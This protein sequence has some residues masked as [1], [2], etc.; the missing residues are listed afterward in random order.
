VNRVL[1]LARKETLEILRDFRTLF[2][3]LFLPIFLYPVLVIGVTFYAAR[4]QTEQARI[5]VVVGVHRCPPELLRSPHFRQG[6]RLVHIPDRASPDNFRVPLER[7]LY[8]AM[9]DC[10]GIHS[11][12][13]RPIRIFYLS[14][15]TD[16]ALA[17]QRVSLAF[18][19]FRESWLLRSLQDLGFSSD[20][21]RAFNP[22]SQD[23]SPPAR[24]SGFILAQILPL[25]LVLVIL[26]GAYHPSMD[27]VVGERERKTVEALLSSPVTAWDILVAKT[28]VISGVAWLAGVLNLVSLTLNLNF[29][30]RLS[31]ELS[32]SLFPGYAP[33]VLVL[34]EMIPLALLF[35]SLFVS[36]SAYS[37]TFRESQSHLVPIIFLVIAP[38][39]VMFLAIPAPSPA[40]HSIPVFSS[41]YLMKATLLGT[42]DPVM[43]VFSSALAVAA[44]ALLLRWGAFLWTSER[45]LYGAGESGLIR[46][47]IPGVVTAT[48]ALAVF[49]VVSFGT[50]VVQALLVPFSVPLAMLASHIAVMGGGV[51]LIILSKRAPLVRTLR[52]FPLG[53]RAIT[54]SVLFGVAAI[55]LS[56]VFSA[57]LSQFLPAPHDLDEK[58]I[59]LIRSLGPV[60]AVIAL[61]F[62][63]AIFEEGLFRGLLFTAFARE[64]GTV[65]GFIL[66][67]VLF[68]SMHFEAPHRIL[69][70]AFLG[71][72]MAYVMLRCGSL[73]AAMIVHLM[74]NGFTVS[75]V[76][77][78]PQ[79]AKVAESDYNALALLSLTCIGIVTWLSAD[80]MAG[81]LQP[82]RPDSDAV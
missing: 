54:S 67:S 28:L 33:L 39:T 44:S 12:P 1:A 78:A 82:T 24:V 53:P 30:A 52:L 38:A 26:Q 59:E 48:E 29:A 60:I 68:G 70:T 51:V 80:W 43:I 65:F 16:S 13:I 45:V 66:S 19:G 22:E 61:G 79:L 4:G 27:L 41:L 42:A 25:I 31:T 63:P 36:A 6:I 55:C 32:A 64:W 35:A 81:L 49:I 18:S 9:I 34:L 46:K 11:S 5:N 50:I 58:I 69:V 47:G 23:L 15:R 71:V 77:L 10:S 76:L 57:S 20:F 7:R 37:R 40:L 62:L 73:L 14:A 2:I 75:L 56:Q 21:G 74:V 72:M 3:L 8:H 17:E